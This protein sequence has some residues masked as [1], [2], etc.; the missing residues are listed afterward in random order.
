[1]PSM[2]FDAADH[3]LFL[4]C[5]SRVTVVVDSN[6]GKVVASLPIGDQADASVFDAF[7]KVAFTSTGDGHIY[8]FRR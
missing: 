8:G 4:G 2:A 3:R 5:R 1:M 7:G 6:T